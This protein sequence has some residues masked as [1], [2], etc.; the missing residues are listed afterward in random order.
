MDFPYRS[1][2]QQAEESLIRIGSQ[3]FDFDR[4]HGLMCSQGAESSYNNQT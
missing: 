1:V 3:N 4:C 2:F